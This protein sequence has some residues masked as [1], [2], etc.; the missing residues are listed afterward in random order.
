MRN[1][2]LILALSC[3][4]GANPVLAQDNEFIWNNGLR[5][6]HFG[7]RTIHDGAGVISLQ[8]PDRA[9]NAAIV[10]IQFEAG[11]PQTPER[12]IRTITVL[13]DNNPEPLVGRFH[14]YPQSGK[15]DMAM[16]VRV[17]A[18]TRLRAIAETNDGRLYMAQHYVKASGGCSAPVGTNIEAALARIGQMRLRLPEVIPGQPVEAQ[19]NISHPNITGL[20][21]DQLTRLYPLAHFV[22]RVEISYAGQPVMTAETDIAISEDPSF[23]FYF[24]PQGE[25]EL[26]AEVFDNKNMHFTLAEPIEPGAN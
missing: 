11:F 20:Q 13:I 18:Y 16:R 3:G 15:A 21:M 6:S 10:P 4:L 14:F 23:R 24:V 8:A 25:G 5:H 26:R 1:L 2:L 12:Y 19:L 9:A 17:N 22:N 7:E